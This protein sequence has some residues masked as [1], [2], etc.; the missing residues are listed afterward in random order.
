M[1]YVMS[2]IHGEYEKYLEMLK[3]IRF[4]DEDEL[5]VLGDVLDRGPEPIKL[6]MDMMYIENYNVFKDIQLLFQT[7]LVLLKAD[8]TEAFRDEDGNKEYI[9]VEAKEEE[10]G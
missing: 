9:F 10:I 8:S 6:I 1:T 5:F 2:D 7:A 4:S 3:L